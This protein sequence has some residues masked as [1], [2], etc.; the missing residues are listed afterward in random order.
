MKLFSHISHE[1]EKRC[2]FHAHW[3]RTLAFE[4][5]QPSCLISRTQ[6]AGGRHEPVACMETWVHGL[7]PT[8]GS[9]GASGENQTV[10]LILLYR[11][12]FIVFYSFLIRFYHFYLFFL[13]VYWLILPKLLPVRTEA[14]CFSK[15]RAVSPSCIFPGMGHLPS[16]MIYCH[17]LQT[18]RVGLAS[19]SST[20]SVPE[21]RPSWGQPPPLAYSSSDRKN[22]T[23]MPQ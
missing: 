23:S 18:A 5:S 8:K 7:Y 14:F 22:T 2:C 21:A 16:S 19:S 4:C 13:I 10:S 1:V 15:G 3:Q 6:E 11:R 12:V 20:H 9:G 17:C